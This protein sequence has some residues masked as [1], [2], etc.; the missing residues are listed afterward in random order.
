MVFTKS[1]AYD[2]ERQVLLP[3]SLISLLHLSHG[4]GAPIAQAKCI[5]APG[6]RWSRDLV[7]ISAPDLSGDRKE[8]SFTIELARTLQIDEFQVL[9]Q[10]RVPVL[11]SVT[12]NPLTP[13]APGSPVPLL[14]PQTDSVQLTIPPVPPGKIV[15]DEPEYE[16]EDSSGNPLAAVRAKVEPSTILDRASLSSRWRQVTDSISFS[17]TED[18]SAVEASGAPYSEGE[19]RNQKFRGIVS[20]ETLQQASVPIEAH[21][22]V[23]GVPLTAFTTLTFEPKKKYVL[24]LSTDSLTL[25]K[26][27]GTFTAEIRE[28]TSGRNDPVPDGVIS[29]NVPDSA[30]PFLSVTP[31]EATGGTLTC[32]VKCIGETTAA[33]VALTVSAR[34]RRQQVPDRPVVM[35]HLD[36]G[37][38][39][40]AECVPD[41]LDP[42]LS[43]DSEGN[44]AVLRARLV[45][46]PTGIA[47]ISFSLENPGGW[48]YEPSPPVLRGGWVCAGITAANPVPDSDTNDPPASENVIVTAPAKDGSGIL[49]S[50][51]VP[52]RLHPRPLLELTPDQPVRLIHESGKEVP[53]G[54]ALVHGERHSWRFTLQPA[55]GQF[56][57]ISA[58]IAREEKTAVKVTVTETGLPFSNQKEHSVREDLVITATPQ[59]VQPS[60]RPERKISVS[61]SREGLF[62]D[63]EKYTEG[64]EVK[65]CEGGVFHIR[66]IEPGDEHKPT[67]IDFRFYS[68]TENQAGL[69]LSFITPPAA[70]L[71]EPADAEK[72]VPGNA[73]R[74]SGLTFAYHETTSFAARYRTKIARDIP[75]DGKPITLHNRVL[76]ANPPADCKGPVSADLVLALHTLDF[77]PGSP[78]YDEELRRCIHIIQTLAPEKHRAE[79]I[80]LLEERTSKFLG[81]EGLFKLRWMIYRRAR[82]LCLDEAADFRD[83][84]QKQEDI[85][86]VLEWAEWAGDLATSALIGALGGG[87][88]VAMV[89]GPLKTWMVKLTNSFLHDEPF[90]ANVIRTVLSIFEGKYVDIDSISRVLG[91]K[92]PLAYTMFI[93][94]H[95]WKAVRWEGMTYTEAAKYVAQQVADELIVRWLRGVLIEHGNKPLSELGRGPAPGTTKAPV[96]GAGTKKPGETGDEGPEGDEGLQK[97]GKK[98]G[99]KEKEPD[100]GKKGKTEEGKPDGKKTGKKDEEKPDEKKTGEKGEKK[101]EEKGKPVKDPAF[102]PAGIEPDLSGLSDWHRKTLEKICKEFD[103]IAHMRPFGDQYGHIAAGRA[104]PKITMIHEKTINPLDKELG[105]GAGDGTLGYAA[106]KKMPD[107]LERK[108]GVSDAKWE[109]LKGRWEQRKKEY[110]LFKDHILEL[111]KKGKVIWDQETGILYHPTTKKPFAGDNDPFAFVDRKTGKPLSPEKQEQFCDKLKQSGIT[112][113]GDHISWDYSDPTN[114]NPKDFEANK[115]I[116]DKILDGHSENSKDGKPVL[117]FNPET[118]KWTTSWWTGGLRT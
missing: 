33:T 55:E 108:P 75:G 110:E 94:Y 78:H 63:R 15:F 52:V 7:S 86:Y 17:L 104:H 76:V 10:P 67:V 27:E 84:A 73:A 116:D 20:R 43:P 105:F 46:G 54:A 100:T 93:V 34:V 88:I 29:V 50:R 118:G 112:M 103:V 47:D 98:E 71:F 77:T 40:E 11:L 99:G 8:A 42:F 38:V 1:F 44:R 65:R 32:T 19:W 37:G 6:C 57:Q 9:V 69:D 68:I 45:P 23:L 36:R 114:K 90:E 107:M 102:K 87:A 24:Y 60:Y 92:K 16:G 30:G 96:K 97:P 35:V 39:L 80:K 21:A 117:T 85:I 59:D 13:P 115:R 41:I 2:P 31:A 74:V 28:E 62:I 113:H 79:L 95:F 109:A 26:G 22:D 51:M 18:S 14:T 89:S 56:R 111:E 48:L 101:P 5:L 82:D 4:G 3:L 70:L 49:A 66:S 58:K 12:L 64:E 25:E 83:A 81:P 106:C 61:V 72:T 91:D 53:L